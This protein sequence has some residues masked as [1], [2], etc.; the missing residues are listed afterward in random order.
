MTTVFDLYHTI[1]QLAPFATAEEWDNVGI[2]AG[3]GGCAVTKV[4]V[5]LDCTVPVIEKARRAG[6]ELVI[7]HHP[8]IFEGL[9][10]LH[11]DS[12]PWKLAE[13]GLSVISAHTNL[14]IAEGGVNDAL[15]EALGLTD[16]E[17]LPIGRLG[18]LPEAMEARDF[19]AYVKAQLNAPGVRFTGSRTVETVALCG[20][21]GGKYLSDALERGADAYVTGEAPHH[22]WLE[23]AERGICLV[24]A[25]HFHTEN[26]VVPSLAEYLRKKHPTVEFFESSACTDDVELI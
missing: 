21:S 12:L 10:V 16:V 4:L 9:R 1:D 23:A 6:A 22:I 19:A 15:A 7:T 26:V 8:V 11:R 13:A 5:A 18:R 2:L 14:D 24:E 3:A 17:P 25:G 20:G